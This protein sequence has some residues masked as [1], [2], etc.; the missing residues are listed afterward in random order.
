MA[1]W[2]FGAKDFK[3]YPHFDKPLPLRE[4]EALV[5]DPARVKSHAF[6][7]FLRYDKK[8]QPFR[9][10]GAKPAKKLRAIRY[11]GRA[12]AYIFGYYRH[13]LSDRY[14]DQLAVH[15]LGDAV[16]AYRK[17]KAG[18]SERGGKCNIHFAH[19]VFQAVH[20]LGNCCVVTL[21]ISSFFE[22]L[23]HARLKE[24]WCNLLGETTLPPDHAAVFKHITRY[25]EV[26]RDDAYL[27]LGYCRKRRSGGLH[28]LRSPRDMPLQLCSPQDFRTKICAAK[29]VKWNKHDFGIPQGAPISDLL[30]NAYLLEFDILMHQYA[31]KRAGIYRRYSDDIL[32]IV[33]GDGRAG[34]AVRKLARRSIKLFGDKL[35]IKEKK[36]ITVKFVRR[37]SVLTASWVHGG[38]RTNGLE[39]L[40]FRFDGTNV[41]LRDSTISNLNRKVTR[42]I[43]AVTHALVARYPGKDGAFI[44]AQFDVDRFMRRY[45]R[46]EE[47]DENAAYNEWTFWSYA[48]RSVEVMGEYS[49]PIYRQLRSLRKQIRLKASQA[50]KE[51]FAG[52]VGSP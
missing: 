45:G 52:P 3:N 18:P 44:L 10:R 49:L 35:E 27:A 30:A 36:A 11:A 12:D 15:G 25:A 43:H 22:S 19:E 8:W 20:R 5:K 39:Y 21:D 14:E 23:D 32:L 50:I 46:V 26:N 4:I 13:L 2:N 38:R 40:G 48:S 9:T 16:I 28:Y 51:R 24:V 34:S 6:F 42:A 17:I 7:P 47:F 1:N 33:P 29:L 37:G 41:F 31:T